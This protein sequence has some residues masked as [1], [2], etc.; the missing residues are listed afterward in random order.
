MSAVAGAIW[1]ANPRQ[2]GNSYLFFSHKIRQ[3]CEIDHWYEPLKRTGDL[4]KKQCLSRIASRWVLPGFGRW[5]AG[6]SRRPSRI[7]AD[8]SQS[9][10]GRLSLTGTLCELSD[11]YA[12]NLRE[13]SSFDGNSL[14]G[15]PDAFTR[16]A[17]S[18]CVKSLAEF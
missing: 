9:N 11:W 5:P 1:H 18:C 2:K 8:N 17:G 15:L 16:P 3:N 7:K 13:F 10:F 14:G 4:R 12:I 6:A